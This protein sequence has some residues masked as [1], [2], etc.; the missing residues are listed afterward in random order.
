MKIAYCP[1]CNQVKNHEEK[2]H[3]Y[4]RLIRCLNCNT[5]HDMEYVDDNEQL[6]DE[7]VRKDT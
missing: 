7:K 3:E 2:R 5:I 6:Y 1:K 4:P